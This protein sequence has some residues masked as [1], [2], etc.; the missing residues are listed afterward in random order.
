MRTET[1]ESLPMFLMQAYCQNGMS[2]RHQTIGRVRRLRAEG[3]RTFIEARAEL[4][5]EFSNAKKQISDTTTSYPYAM[6]TSYEHHPKLA[7]VI[8]SIIQVEMV[9]PHGEIRRV[10]SATHGSKLWPFVMR[11]RVRKTGLLR[12]SLCMAYRVLDH[13][14]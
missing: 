14:S 8:P 9:E 11:Q 10:T 13:C 12:I 1:D 3:N 4:L 7:G 2:G 5:V 6:S